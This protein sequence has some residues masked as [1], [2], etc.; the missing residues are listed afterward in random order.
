MESENTNKVVIED[1][2]VKR[3][4][5][6]SKPSSAKWES[7]NT[8]SEGVKVPRE[9]FLKSD[10]VSATELL[11]G[12]LGFRKSITCTQQ[13]KEAYLKAALS[14]SPLSLIVD[15]LGGKMRLKF[16]ARN[17]NDQNVIVDTVKYR[18]SF[19]A[20]GVNMVRTNLELQQ[21]CLIFML[22]EVN[23]TPFKYHVKL[24][25]GSNYV[26]AFDPI[27]TALENMRV[28]LPD[29]I[30]QL[31]LNGMII[32]TEKQALMQEMCLNRDFWIPA[33]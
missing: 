11:S 20:D 23:G 1:E 18:A 9:P 14:E 28:E 7:E 22:E 26:S 33:G 32:F 19:Y 4:L 10:D 17:A 12:A 8:P 6:A 2:D 30:W 3:F 24:P 13:D 5:G 25:S 16:K 15:M 21:L 29:N 31:Y 27:N